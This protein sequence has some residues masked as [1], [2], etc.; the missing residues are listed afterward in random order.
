MNRPLTAPEVRRMF[1][2]SDKAEADRLER[3]IERERV[4][5]QFNN[6]LHAMFTEDATSCGSCG[7]KR[8]GCYCLP[9]S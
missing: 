2:A 6:E 3:R 7:N 8:E 1:A 5:R 4:N 9:S